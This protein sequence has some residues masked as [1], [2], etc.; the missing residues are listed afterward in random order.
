MIRDSKTIDNDDYIVDNDSFLN[1][2]KVLDL[3]SIEDYEIFNDI[4][5]RNNLVL[6]K[7]DLLPIYNDSDDFD[8]IKYFFSLAKK[9]LMKRLNNKVPSNYATRLMYE[10]DIINK[11]GFSNYFLVVYDYVKY[12]KKNN[13]LVGPGRGSVAGSLVSYSLGITEIDP[14]KYNLFFERFLNP[15]R[16]TMPDIDIDFEA[17]KRDLVIDYVKEKY[18][19]DKVAQI[20]TFGTLKSKMVLRDLSRVF[21]IEKNIDSFIK[22][23]DSKLSLKDNLKNKNIIDIMKKDTLLSKIV[24]ISIKL[25]DIKRHSSIHAAGVVISKE[26]L[27]NYC[28]LTKND[29]NLVIGFTKDYLEK[30]GLLKMDFLAIDNL[31]LISNIINEANIDLKSIDFNDEKTLE[32]FRSVKTDGIFQFESSG[33]KNVLRKFPVTSFNDL[34]AILAL[35]RPGPMQF[36]DS[37]IKRKQNKEKIDYIDDRIKDILVDTY[38]IIVYQEQVMQIA[39]VMAGYSL[40]EADML[41]K[42]M[43]KSSMSVSNNEREKFINQSIK[44]GFSKEVSSKTYDMI[45]NFITSFGFN[46]SHSVGY[47]YVSYQMA[48]LKAHYSKYFM[49]YLLSMVIGNEIKTKEYINELKQNNIEVLKPNINYSDIKYTIEKDCI[50]FPLNGIKNI[51]QISCLDIIKEREKGLFTDFFDFVRR[52][53]SKSINKKVIEYL[54]NSGCF[55]DFN[56]NRKTLIDNIDSAINY[57]DLCNDLD[58]KLIEKPDMEISEE[59]SKDELTK[60]EYETFGFYFTSHPIQKYRQNEIYTTN[61]SK[62]FDKVITIYLLIDKKRE[63]ITKK[64]DKMAFLSASDEFSNIELIIFPKV[65][66]KFYSIDRKDIVK[67]IGRVQKNNNEYQLV[68]NDLYKLN[69]K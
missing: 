54:I 66:E 34:I 36:I 8:E 32:I 15:E 42:M 12:A 25:E 41:R 19:E 44:N 52:C 35:F 61:I 14:I 45:Y 50:R 48:Y 51:G 5:N 33:I 38:G 46:K 3:L 30:L 20:I 6:E 39:N 1:N 23:F 27:L 40:K 26:K 63:I 49:K 53:Y 59:Y 31:T 37:Y 58:Y 67:V 43:S 18:G 64:K 65:Y 22:L 10:L 2:K 47:A 62:Y 57:S 55:D 16:I 9:G 13:I 69:S 24:D 11:M 68:V 17:T 60:K 21:K 7:N 4:Y 28:P 56:Y 29:D